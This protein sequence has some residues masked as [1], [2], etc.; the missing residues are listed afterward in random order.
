MRKF[1]L[2]ISCLI[3]TAGMSQT[4]IDNVCYNLNYDF[5]T[6]EVTS[7]TTKYSGTLFVPSIVYENATK[8]H[9]TVT[10]IGIRAFKDCFN[11]TTVNIPSSVKSIGDYAFECSGLSYINIPNSV[12]YIGRE[13][14]SEC[15]NLTSIVLPASVT[16]IGKNAFS[17]CDELK[18]ITVM[19]GKP[20]KIDSTSFPD[21]ANQI[22]FVPKGSKS[23]YEGAEFWRDFKEIID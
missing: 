16:T 12:N 23:A 19:N 20:V 8:S 6:A 15:R 9:L 11:L 4:A 10:T 5:K 7:S 18:Q 22:L 21:R 17:K 2:F 14:F 3:A 1:F 13:A